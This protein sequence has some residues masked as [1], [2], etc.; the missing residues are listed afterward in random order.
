MDAEPTELVGP[1]RLSVQDSIRVLRVLNATGDQNKVKRFPAAYDII[2][3]IKNYIAACK[4]KY[5]RSA[6]AKTIYCQLCSGKDD[7]SYSTIVWYYNFHR[8]GD[9]IKSVLRSRNVDPDVQQIKIWKQTYNEITSTTVTASQYAANTEPDQ[10]QLLLEK[11][12]NHCKN[13]PECFFGSDF[14]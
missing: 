10:V 2:S 6:G 3:K 11:Y 7:L 5:G 1:F 8:M 14:E 4:Q 13:C 12:R 9:Q